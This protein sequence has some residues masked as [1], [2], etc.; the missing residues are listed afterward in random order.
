VPGAVEQ[1]VPVSRERW[2][3]VVSID[4]VHQRQHLRGLRAGAQ[5]QHCSRAA[6]AAPSEVCLLRPLVP[7]KWCE[8][9]FCCGTCNNASPV[10]ISLLCG[11][12][13]PRT[14]EGE[15]AM[16]GNDRDRNGGDVPRTVHDALFKRCFSDPVLAAQELRAVLPPALVASVDWSVMILM[17]TSFVDAVFHQRTSDL[18]YRGRFLGGGDVIW[19]LEHQRSEDWWMLERVFDTKR[20]MWSRWRQQHSEARHL[21][22]IVPVV[23]YNGPRPW[24][25]PRDMHALY[26]V[27]ENVRTAIDPHVLSCTLFIDD[28]SAITDDD[29]RA[30]PMD[31]YGRLCLFAMARAAGK[32]F[33]DRLH[34]WQRELRH[35]FESVD[36]ER[37]LSFLVY[38]S[39]VH[40]HA[41]PDTIRKR[42]AALVGP[43]QET[44]VQTFYEMVVQEGYEKGVAEQRAILLRQLGRR[45]GAVPEPI[46]A[47]VAAATSPELERW[48]DRVL[49]AASLD[50]VFASE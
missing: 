16:T 34:A 47:R 6:G 35:L 45:F 7:E 50:D 37:I 14:A 27:S 3:I 46:A 24:R 39:R 10:P 42:I 5:A 29:L 30:R 17:P 26:G 19:L 4:D 32:D 48:F 43:K 15:S 13:R 8:S 44:A 23:V 22:A 33:L 18:V 25:A 20:M 21:P 40:R 28:L 1:L 49:D 2:Q 38:T 36:A 9:F 11:P 12:A 41:D 31:A